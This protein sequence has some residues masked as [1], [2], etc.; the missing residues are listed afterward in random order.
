MAATTMTRRR[1]LAACGQ[2][3]A[4]LALA[5]AVLLGLAGA[6]HPHDAAASH[7]GFAVKGLVHFAG[8]TSPA[9]GATVDL[10][11]RA[12]DGRWYWA[13]VRATA[14]ANGHYAFS[15]LRVGVPYAVRGFRAYSFCAS[16]GVVDQYL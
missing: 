7:A 15:G 8:T 3:T 10:A 9:A 16:H 12:S 11:Y 2:R 14:D 5:L 13:N 6:A 4:G 1:A